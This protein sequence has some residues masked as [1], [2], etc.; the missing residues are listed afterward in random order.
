MVG[1]GADGDSGRTS[2]GSAPWKLV[3]ASGR[4]LEVSYLLPL[5]P[6]IES[7]LEAVHVHETPHEVLIEVI[8][9]VSMPGRETYAFGRTTTH[10][11]ALEHA[12]GQRK[13]QHADV[14]SQMRAYKPV[15]QD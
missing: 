8:T 9:S 15:S 10:V 12:L 14:D 13:I 1:C 5:G 2:L 11:V 3:S 6:G 4:T 7:K